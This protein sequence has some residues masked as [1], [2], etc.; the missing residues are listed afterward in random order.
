MKGGSRPHVYLEEWILSKG[1]ENAR[2]LEGSLF[3]IF[4]K[5]QGNQV[6]TECREVARHWGHGKDLGLFPKGLR[7]P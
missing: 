3:G 2:P 4:E 5:Q 1:T 7:T 6:R